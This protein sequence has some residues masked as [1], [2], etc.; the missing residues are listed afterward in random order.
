MVGDTEVLFSAM[1][2]SPGLTDTLRRMR[3]KA[4]ML[5]KAHQLYKKMA[6]DEQAAAATLEALSRRGMFARV[7]VV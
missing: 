7:A 2:L 1:P 5:G 4:E 3:A 6:E